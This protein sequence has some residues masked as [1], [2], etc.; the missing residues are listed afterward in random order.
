MTQYDEYYKTVNDVR[1]CASVKPK[2]ASHEFSR[3]ETVILKVC[4]KKFPIWSPLQTT[5]PFA[6]CYDCA[7]PKKK[8]GKR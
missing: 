2:Y 8:K 6:Q 1:T 3:T 5:E 7:H 4:G